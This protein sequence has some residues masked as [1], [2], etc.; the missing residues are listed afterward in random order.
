MNDD[1]NSETLALQ[2]QIG[3][4]NGSLRVRDEIIRVRDERIAALEK[5]LSEAHAK[6]AAIA[7]MLR[8]KPQ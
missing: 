3:Q 7:R 5:Q 6:A 2:K 4:L 1:H 8:D